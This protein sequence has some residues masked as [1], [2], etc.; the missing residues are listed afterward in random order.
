MIAS[1][2]ILVKTLKDKGFIITTSV[3][4]DGCDFVRQRMVYL[5]K[6][7]KET[8]EFDKQLTDLRKEGVYPN[9][10]DEIRYR[11]YEKKIFK[12]LKLKTEKLNSFY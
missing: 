10:A 9:L 3:F 4:G 6:A 12:E 11:N 2:E 8:S 5:Y 1:L 7:F